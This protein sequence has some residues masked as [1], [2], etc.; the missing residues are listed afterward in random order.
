MTAVLV[1]ATGS[2][3]TTRKAFRVQESPPK[4]PLNYFYVFRTFYGDM[5]LL[6]RQ[7][8]PLCS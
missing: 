3:V 2:V 5:F 4:N 6:L 8:Q 1:A 7:C